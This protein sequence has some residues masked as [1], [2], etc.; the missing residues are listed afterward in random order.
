MLKRG[1][2]AVQS[3]L[4]E[5]SLH[6][7]P[8]FCFTSLSDSCFLLLIWCLNW[9][10]QVFWK[11]I[12]SHYV[13]QFMMLIMAEE[14]IVV[15]ETCMTVLSVLFVFLKGGSRIEYMFPVHLSC[16]GASIA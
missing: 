12:V 5:N 9:E 13:P 4:A 3:V 15:Y 14:C 8:Q 1:E 16:L 2:N 11:H 7:K 10:D 6:F